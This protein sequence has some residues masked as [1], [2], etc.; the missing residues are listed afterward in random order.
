LSFEEKDAIKT[1]SSE[2]DWEIS[3]AMPNGKPQMENGKSASLA[4]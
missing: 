4:Y 3:L 2:G 1:P